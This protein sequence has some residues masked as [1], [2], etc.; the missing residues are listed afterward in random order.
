MIVQG[1]FKGFKQKEQEEAGFA[2]ETIISLQTTRSFQ[3]L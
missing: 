2:A 3:L 1:L